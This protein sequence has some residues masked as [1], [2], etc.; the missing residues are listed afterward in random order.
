MEQAT[1]QFAHEIRNQYMLAYTPT[2]PALDG[3]FRKVRV[4]VNGP[5]KPTVRTRTGYFATPEAKKSPQV[6]Q[7]TSSR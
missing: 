5:G 2:N 7:N 3:T 4:A 1:L 6:S